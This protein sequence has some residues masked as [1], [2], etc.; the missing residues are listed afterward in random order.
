MK[1]MMLG[2][3]AATG[4]AACGTSAP[5]CAAPNAESIVQATDARRILRSSLIDISRVTTTGRIAAKQDPTGFEERLSA[6]VTDAVDRHGAEWEA[7][8]VK[9]FASTLS[10]DELQAACTALNEGD[11]ETFMRLASRV[12]EELNSEAGSVLN[13]AGA[14]VLQ[15]LFD[16]SARN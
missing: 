13:S 16:G 15:E 14:D 1:N 6:A 4:L 8:M 3:V 5:H 9:A 10:A 7:D 2:L 12:W 11:R